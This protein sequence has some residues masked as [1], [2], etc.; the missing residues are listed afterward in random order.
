M[1]SR[2]AD[3]GKKNKVPLIVGIGIAVLLLGAGI[4]YAMSS[5]EPDY[6]YDQGKLPTFQN[7]NP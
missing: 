7:E 4:F 6:N 1:G 2:Y 5:S 3:K